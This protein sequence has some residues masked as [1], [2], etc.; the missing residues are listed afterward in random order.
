M[1]YLAFLQ[2]KNSQLHFL[3][4]VTTIDKKKRLDVMWDY[5]K[6]SKATAKKTEF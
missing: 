2:M 6:F 3:P 5:D 4:I 1:G